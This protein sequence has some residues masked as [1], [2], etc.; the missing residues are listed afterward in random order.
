M[1]VQQFFSVTLLSRN[2]IVQVGRAAGKLS[3][4]RSEPWPR[5][6]AAWRFWSGFDTI[7]GARPSVAAR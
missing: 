7:A 6:V 5:T 1:C 3:G 4:A 2:L